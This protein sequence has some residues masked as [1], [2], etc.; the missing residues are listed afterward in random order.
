MIFF[1]CSA[2]ASAIKISGETIGF[3][4]Q[5]HLGFVDG[6]GLGVNFGLDAGVPA[7]DFELGAEIEQSVTDYRFDVN[8]NPTKLGILLRYTAI[9]EQLWV[10]V[11]LGSVQFTASKDTYYMDTFSGDRIDIF[12]E[13][14]TRGSYV[15]ASLD[16]KMGDF[17]LT[18]RAYFNYINGGMLPEFD[19]NLGV[20]I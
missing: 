8:M 1:A 15:S 9:P 12:G 11:H 13:E 18:P 17:V 19:L 6:F 2:P 16:Y 5:F 3:M 20:R 4:S 7:G 10:A 14:Q